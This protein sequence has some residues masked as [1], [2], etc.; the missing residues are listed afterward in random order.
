[1]GLKIKV[2][3]QWVDTA[4]EHTHDLTAPVV[5]TFDSS[6]TWT[7]PAGAFLI[8]VEV[9]AGGGGGSKYFGGA[10]GG[11]IRGEYL[12]Q[13]LP[14][15]VSVTVGAGG[16]GTNGGNA[17][18][19]G[20]SSFGS[21]LSTTGGR[22]NVSCCSDSTQGGGL[23]GGKAARDSDTEG[24]Y[25]AE[26]S[27]YGGGGGGHGYSYYESIKDGGSS[28]YG[29]GGGA[30]AYDGSVTRYGGAS[31]FGGKGG[32]FITGVGP[33]NGEVPGG[34]GA[35]RINTATSGLYGGSGGHGRVRV[36]TYFN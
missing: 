18:A 6:G 14:E 36:T 31:V 11:Y 15:T 16:A 28:V 24:R 4:G 34:G 1:M 8:L 22:A 2:G 17:T 21:I 7:K 26:S 35:A 27:E 9:W 30:G 19:G 13:H 10:G 23:T 5:E 3:G 32:D 33:Q 20:S 25:R 29:G 12:P